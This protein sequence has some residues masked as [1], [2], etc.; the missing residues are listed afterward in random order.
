MDEG[1]HCL[2]CSK[3][4]NKLLFKV[5]NKQTITEADFIVHTK[6]NKKI[7]KHIVIIKKK[8]NKPMFFE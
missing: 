1:C 8:Q 4:R 3:K 6:N 5:K 2:F 7:N